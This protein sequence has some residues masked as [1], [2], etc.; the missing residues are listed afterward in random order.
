MKTEV[1]VASGKN[2]LTATE[3]SDE[4][5]FIRNGQMN[6]INDGRCKLPP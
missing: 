4:C 6:I 5:S 3:F 2:R 1:S